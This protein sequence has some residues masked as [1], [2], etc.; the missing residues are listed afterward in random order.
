MTRVVVSCKLQL[1]TTVVGFLCLQV[2]YATP[3]SGGRGGRG[4]G[5][6]KERVGSVREG[7]DGGGKERAGSVREEWGGGGGG[8][9]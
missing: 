2:N 1:L 6:G 4:G 7:C 5:G 3:K 8:H 9:V